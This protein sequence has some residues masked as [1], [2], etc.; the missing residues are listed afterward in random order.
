[1]NDVVHPWLLPD[2]VG[3]G[4]RALQSSPYINMPPRS[5]RVVARYGAELEA[6]ER[7]HAEAAITAARHDTEMF[8]GKIHPRVKNDLQFI[9]SIALHAGPDGITLSIRDI[10]VALPT[11]MAS[12]PPTPSSCNWSTCSPRSSVTRSRCNASAAPL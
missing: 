4:A 1:M 3:H 12:R 11:G 2:K 6:A 5:R 10:G 8:L 9:P 7:E